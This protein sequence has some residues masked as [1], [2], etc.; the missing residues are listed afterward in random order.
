MAKSFLLYRHVNPGKIL[1]RQRHLE[2]SSVVW[3]KMTIYPILKHR[4]Y[5]LAFCT[6]EGGRVN[7]M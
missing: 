3:K 1:N 5:H 6:S 7:K 2:T 4:T